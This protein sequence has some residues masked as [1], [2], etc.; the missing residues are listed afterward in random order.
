MR[1][2][3]KTTL[4]EG[5][6]GVPST[7]KKNSSGA[8]G[9]GGKMGSIRFFGLFCSPQIAK[10]A[11]VAGFLAEIFRRFAPVTGKTTS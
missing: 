1:W 3:G 10:Q 4:R 9:R 7:E 6:L 5:G 11:S 2:V 8:A